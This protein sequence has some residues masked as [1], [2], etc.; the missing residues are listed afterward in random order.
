MPEMHNTNEFHDAI[1]RLH[2]FRAYDRPA[3][4]LYAL[5]NEIAVGVRAGRYGDRP[6]DVM[7]VDPAAG[8]TH[9][10]VYHL[11]SSPYVGLVRAL[12][13][14]GSDSNQHGPAERWLPLVAAAAGARENASRVAMV[15]LLID[16]G[17]DVRAA[18]PDGYTALHCATSLTPIEQASPPQTVVDLVRLLLDHGADPLAPTAT[19]ETTLWRVCLPLRSPPTPTR[20]ELVRLLRAAA[21]GE[22]AK[23]KPKTLTFKKR[24]EGFDLARE[25]GI[26]ALATYVRNPELG[27]VFLAVR[28]PVEETA[29]AL[30]TTVPGA[31]WEAACGKR[32]VE[33]G[34]FSCFVAR[35][36]PAEWTLVLYGSSMLVK[37]PLMQRIQS[38]AAALA[39]TLGVEVVAAIGKRVVVEYAAD[40]APT[41]HEY[42][43]DEV[44]YAGAKKELLE[45]LRAKR[46][47]VPPFAITS[48]GLTLELLLHGVTKEHLER[49]D[50]VVFKEV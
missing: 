24:K 10:V 5:E 8:W 36:V 7:V 21:R 9:P 18:S 43:E 1:L 45:L 29:R 11:V 46:V 33:D 44:F 48:N 50:A 30:S 16:R 22:M 3:D 37:L 38:H 19:G 25:V 6:G 39:T 40:G 4:P 2:P 23:R 26:D 27:W 49:L 35:L 42:G 34:A 17:A 20:T 15:Q 32:H 14:A 12:L 31:R 47:F 41:M 13:E 28:A